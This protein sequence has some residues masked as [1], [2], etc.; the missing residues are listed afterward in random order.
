MSA[1]EKDA[2]KEKIKAE[3]EARKEE[4]KKRWEEEKARRKEERE[5][6]FPFRSLFRSEN[7]C[8]KPY[9]GIY[10]VLKSLKFKNWFLR[11]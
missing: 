9:Q 3:R 11:P 7:S 6:V 8:V 10:N 4:L 1:E 5:Q 2:L